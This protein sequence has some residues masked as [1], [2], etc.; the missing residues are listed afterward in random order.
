MDRDEERAIAWDC[1]RI[2]TK[3]CLFNDGKRSDELA[4]LFT[5][6]GV[7]IRLGQSL[8][9]R[10]NI[11]KAME[12]RPATALHLHV[13][14]NVIVTVTDADQAEVTSCKSIYYDAAGESLDKPIP[15]NGPKWVSVYTDKF[16]RT[17]EGWRIARME[18]TT[19]FER[20]PAP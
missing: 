4:N 11:R 1:Q 16:M 10:E 12:A 14:S 9:G 8:T 20:E 5:P 13:L 18:G 6:D 15:L 2:L 19:L 3:F 17:D 7:W